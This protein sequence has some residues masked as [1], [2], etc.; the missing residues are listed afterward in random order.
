MTRPLT[1]YLAGDLDR[2]QRWRIQVIQAF[3]DREDIEFLCPVDSIKYSHQSLS[4]HH[5]ADR[6]FHV[7]DKLKIQWA[8]LIFAY[9]R[10][11]SD[12][13]FS[14]TSW[15][16]GWGGTRDKQIIMVSNMKPAEAHLDELVR[17]E[18]DIYCESIEEGIACLRDI[19]DSMGYVPEGE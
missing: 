14:G 8:D 6:T 2:E 7:A 17:R 4:K 9:F 11:G 13:K 10:Q 18:V 5:I 1:V 19:A 16:C 3:A 15:E 12:S